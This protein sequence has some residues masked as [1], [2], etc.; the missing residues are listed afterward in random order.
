IAIE[1]MTCPADAFNN[2]IGLLTLSPNQSQTFTW[3]CQANYQPN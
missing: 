3:Q 1:P 2:Q